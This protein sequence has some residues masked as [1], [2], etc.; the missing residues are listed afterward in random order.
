MQGVRSGCQVA[1]DNDRAVPR[2][3]GA[4]RSLARTSF[5]LGTNLYG[6]PTFAA[7]S[8]HA[9]PLPGRTVTSR[10]ARRRW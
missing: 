5:T 3:S 9:P 1:H 10:A 6:L 7:Q 8:S 4:I 2:E